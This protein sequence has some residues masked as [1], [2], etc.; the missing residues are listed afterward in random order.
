MRDTEA[1]V[2]VAAGVHGGGVGVVGDVQGVSGD[3]VE[4]LF[5]G[6]H[7]Y[8]FKLENDLVTAQFVTDFRVHI[9]LAVRHVVGLVVVEVG[10]DVEHGVFGVFGVYF[11]KVLAL[12]VLGRDHVVPAVVGVF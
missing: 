7:A 2:E 10:D 3:D 5:R 1:D 4:L 9:D 11:Y 8:R 12:N 6:E